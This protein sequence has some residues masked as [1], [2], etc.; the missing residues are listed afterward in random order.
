MGG[1]MRGNRKLLAT[2]ITLAML[3]QTGCAAALWGNLLIVVLTLAIFVGIIRLAH[4]DD[5]H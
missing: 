4:G 2:V 5:E 1:K 3:G